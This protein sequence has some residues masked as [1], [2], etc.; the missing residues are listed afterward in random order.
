MKT[1]T[2]GAPSYHAIADALR[3]QIT[4]GELPPG[5]D[6][7]SQTELAA[8]YGVGAGTARLALNALVTEGLIS[9]GR[10]RGRQVRD[11][12]T[13]HVYATRSESMARRA[14][15]S[16]D[17]WMTDVREQGLEPAQEIKVELVK[18]D[19]E[20]ARVLELDPGA[21]VVVRRRIR[22]V[23][24]RPDNLNDTYYDHSLALE[25]PEILNPDDVTQ[26]IVALMRGRGYPQVRYTHE[27]RWRPPTPDEAKRLELPPGVAVLVQMNT[28]YTAERPVKTTIT[29]WPGDS[30]VLIYELPA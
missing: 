1:A 29:T 23:D 26:G 15:A 16:S 3:Q 20:I 12:R 18:A 11:R 19:P 30:H 27:L 14:D 25:I 10:G 24:G 13:L 7:P 9:S 21:L 5:A 22:T 8:E 17:A 2:N 6:V 28:G 4:S